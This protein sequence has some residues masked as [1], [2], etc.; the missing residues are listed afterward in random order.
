MCEGMI[1]ALAEDEHGSRALAH[2][3]QR[4]RELDAHRRCVSRALLGRSIG[5]L[6]EVL[7]ASVATC[8]LT[9]VCGRAQLRAQPVA[10]LPRVVPLGVARLGFWT[11]H[12]LRGAART[13]CVHG[14]F[15]V[16][17]LAAYRGIGS[18]ESSC[19]VAPAN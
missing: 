13:W 9:A 3:Q 4:V 8:E 1:E 11:A 16:K 15:L 2:T 7:D 14:L 18:N 6:L 5:E 19:V 10:L 17:S 12:L